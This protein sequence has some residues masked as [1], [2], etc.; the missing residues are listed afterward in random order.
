[1][2]L[3]AD[4]HPLNCTGTAAPD[5][6]RKTRSKSQT[7][8]PSDDP[9]NDISTSGEMLRFSLSLGVQFL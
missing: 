6:M 3:L 2:I 8:A 7:A 4:P 5:L 1:M 9:C